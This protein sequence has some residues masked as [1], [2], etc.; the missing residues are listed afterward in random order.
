MERPVA[1]SAYQ[2]AAIAKKEGE[3]SVPGEL[4]ARPPSGNEEFFYNVELLAESL[5]PGPPTICDDVER[6]TTTG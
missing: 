1:R 4:M 2:V 3:A 5:F 6:P